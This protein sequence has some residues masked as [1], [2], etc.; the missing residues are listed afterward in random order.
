MLVNAHFS[1]V[2]VPRM[3]RGDTSVY[4][5]I[6]K[7]HYNKNLIELACSVRIREYCSCSFFV[8][9]LPAGRSI[10]F[11]IREIEQSFSKTDFMA[12]VCSRYNARSDWLI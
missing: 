7:S 3:H 12:S 2:C 6:K 8:T 9:N 1:R 11:A 10:N 5:Q 4:L